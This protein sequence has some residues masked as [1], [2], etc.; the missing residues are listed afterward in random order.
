MEKEQKAQFN[1][2]IFCEFILFLGTS[3]NYIHCYYNLEIV[4]TWYAGMKIILILMFKKPNPFM[5]LIDLNRVLADL[6]M[7]WGGPDSPWPGRPPHCLLC[8]VVCFPW[9]CTSSVHSTGYRGAP[10]QGTV[11]HRRPITHPVNRDLNVIAE[12]YM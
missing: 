6:H 12:S 11:D 3:I 1:K 2:E 9:L 5:V 4:K 8:I 7:K 10:V